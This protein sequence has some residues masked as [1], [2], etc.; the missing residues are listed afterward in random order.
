M[1]L[2]LRPV[3]ASL[4]ALLTATLANAI[5]STDADQLT[6]TEYDFVVV[7]GASISSPRARD[8]D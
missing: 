8:T 5:V 6:N 7:G 1:A 2:A 3:F 4:V